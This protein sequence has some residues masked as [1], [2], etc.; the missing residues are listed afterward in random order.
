MNE[1]HSSYAM[2]PKIQFCGQIPIFFLII[3]LS[4][5]FSGCEASSREE[6]PDNY[7]KAI[8]LLKNK[9]WKNYPQTIYCGASYDKN[10]DINLPAGFSTPAHQ[11][12][13]KRIEWEHAVP[14]ENF[15]RA[16]REWREGDPVCVHKGKPYKG[17]KCA[18][19]A[20]EEFRRMEADMYNL[21]PAIGAVNAVRGNKQYAELPGEE[22]SFGI[23]EAKVRDNNFEPTDRSKGQVARAALYMDWKYKS[24]RLSDRQ[25]RLFNAWNKKFPAERDECERAR[26]IQKLQKT[27]NIFI[28]K[29]CSER[30]Y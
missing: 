8:K 2:I 3:L 11:K 19:K 29:S 7:A 12:R 22:A 25:K 20:N 16:F 5:P 10:G 13:A 14:A 24:Y 9:V 27:E 1:D 15:G 18:A 17:R 21:F 28:S 6:V 30:G 4:L 26:L 23:C